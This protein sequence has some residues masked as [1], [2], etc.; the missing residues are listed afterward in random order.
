MQETIVKRLETLTL[1]PPQTYRNITIFPFVDGDGGG[2]DYLTLGE[3]LEQQRLT[4]TEV[5]EHGSVPYLQV[6]ND[7]DSMVLLL[8]GEELAGAKQNR[9]LNTTVLVAARQSLTIPVSCTEAGRW[10]H[11]TRTAYESQN[12]MECRIR[13][14]KNLA[15]SASLDLE[16]SYTSD[17]GEIWDDIEDLSIAAGV[18][19]DTGAM[20]DIYQSQQASLD[21]VLQ[22]FPPVPGQVGF[23]AVIDGEAAGLDLVSR[24]PAYARLHGKLVR[25]YVMAGLVRGE[26]AATETQAGGEAQEADQAGAAGAADAAVGLARTFL[27]RAMRSEVNPFE[28]VGCGE[29]YRLRGDRITGS[30]LVLDQTVVHAAIFQLGDEDRD[31]DWDEEAMDH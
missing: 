5:S 9:V 3:A 10:R 2:V 7:G 25:S 11:D 31:E 30:A 18:C 19:S 26:E 21:E 13:A 28:S 23:L 15:V 12:I 17:Q 20:S 16:Q 6:V 29:D 14:R 1:D 4:V 24:A 27:A 8:D 22:A